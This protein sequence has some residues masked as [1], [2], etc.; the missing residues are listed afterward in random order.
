MI[1][2]R[3]QRILVFVFN[4]VLT[5]DIVHNIQQSVGT[6]TITKGSGNA[7]FFVGLNMGE[8]YE[9]EY[10]GKY[11]RDLDG[12]KIHSFSLWFIYLTSS[13]PLKNDTKKNS[14]LE[15]ETNSKQSN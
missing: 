8:H 3:L 4:S 10:Y 14:N 15:Y 5:N 12:N 7:P 1:Y 11:V 13:R 6:N 2:V 9:K